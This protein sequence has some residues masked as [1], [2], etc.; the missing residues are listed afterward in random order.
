MSETFI[1]APATFTQTTL[2]LM[3][4]DKLLEGN[5][6]TGYYYYTVIKIAA[7]VRK[8][9]VAVTMQSVGNEPFTIEYGKNTRWSVIEETHE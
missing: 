1:K 4:G 2:N 3:P 9:M 5:F 8:N 7:G 6:V